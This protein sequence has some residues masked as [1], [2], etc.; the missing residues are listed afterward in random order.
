VG[1][2][3]VSIEEKIEAALRERLGHPMSVVELVA[4][5]PGSTI[6]EIWAAC[7]RLRD[8]GRLGRNGADTP[9][10]PYRFYLKKHGDI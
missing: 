7:T 5:I 9:S 2:V 3:A 4:V 1:D 6:T 10:S 8:Q